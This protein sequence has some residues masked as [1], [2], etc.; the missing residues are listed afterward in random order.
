MHDGTSAVFWGC[1]NAAVVDSLC[2]PGSISRPGLQNVPEHDAVAQPAIFEHATAAST[3]RPVTIPGRL[4]AP[5]QA[6]QPFI[7]TGPAVWS[8]TQP[9]VVG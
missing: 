1:L 6:Q 3:M 8:K 2:W 5:V 4:V 9:E 7:H